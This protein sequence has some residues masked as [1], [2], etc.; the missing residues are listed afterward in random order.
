MGSGES[1]FSLVVEPITIGHIERI[2]KGRPMP[3]QHP[4]AKRAYITHEG[5]FFAHP[6]R[7]VLVIETDLHTNPQHPD[8][9]AQKLNDLI[10]AGQNYVAAQSRQIDGFQIVPANDP[11]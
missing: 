10:N 5:R 6:F 7:M 2:R 8:F 11:I 1:E 9:D 4:N 3:I